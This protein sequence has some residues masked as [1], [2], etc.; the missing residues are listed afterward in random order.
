MKSL[1]AT[2]LFAITLIISAQVRIVD[3]PLPLDGDPDARR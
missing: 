1:F 3:R 2:A